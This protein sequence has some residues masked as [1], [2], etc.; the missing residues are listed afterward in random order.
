VL[1]VSTAA[2]QEAG[3]QNDTGALEPIWTSPR[4]LQHTDTEPETHTL[5]RACMGIAMHRARGG[6]RRRPLIRGLRSSFA[7]ASEEGGSATGHHW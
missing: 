3:G 5:A 4:L 1:S 7:G 6:A 2:R